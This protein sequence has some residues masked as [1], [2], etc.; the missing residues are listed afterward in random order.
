MG[1]NSSRQEEEGGNNTI[2]TMTIIMTIIITIITLIFIYSQYKSNTSTKAI[3]KSM[4][5]IYVKPRFS[6]IKE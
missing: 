1:A 4:K 5:H 2:I 6:T 3:K